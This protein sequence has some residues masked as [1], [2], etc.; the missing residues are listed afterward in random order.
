MRRLFFSGLALILANQINAQSTTS[1]VGVGNVWGATKYLGWDG[2]SGVN[3]LLFKTNNLNRM[4]LNGNLTYSVNSYSQT[5]NGYLLIGPD[6]PM[7]YG[8]PNELYSNY[9]AFSQL[10]LNG[11]TGK[12][13]CMQVI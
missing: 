13:M 10:H 4:K 3:P 6:M 1:G 11:E 9:G 5:R 2:A 8:G 12:S 7:S